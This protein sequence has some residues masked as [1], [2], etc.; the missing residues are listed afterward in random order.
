MTVEPDNDTADGCTQ[1]LLGCLYIMVLFI[2]LALAFG[3][4]LRACAWAVDLPM[5][6]PP[7]TIGLGG[8]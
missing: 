2:L 6:P 7:T 8:D 4:A 5:S 1:P 3:V